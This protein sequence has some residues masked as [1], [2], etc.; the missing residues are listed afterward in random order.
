MAEV[1]IDLAV[2][3]KTKKRETKNEVG[4]RSEKRNEAEESNI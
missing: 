3:R 2:G 4:Q 1:N